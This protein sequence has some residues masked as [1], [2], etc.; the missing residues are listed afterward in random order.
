M[1][2]RRLVLVAMMATDQL[3]LPQL[4]QPWCQVSTT[5]SRSLEYSTLRPPRVALV[6]SFHTSWGAVHLA[7]CSCASFERA[8]LPA[9]PAFLMIS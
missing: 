4:Q 1:Q 7:P 9:S 5:S 2:E 6:S 3:L 8:L